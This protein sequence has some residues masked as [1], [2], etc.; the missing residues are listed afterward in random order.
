[1]DSLASRVAAVSAHVEEI[2]PSRQAALAEAADA[3][4]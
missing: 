2:F 1:M 3:A 4:C